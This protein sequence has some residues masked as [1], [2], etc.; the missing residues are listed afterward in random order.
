MATIEGPITAG[1][2]PFMGAAV[3]G[4]GLGYTSAEYFIELYPA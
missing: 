2:G 3:L 1:K 4:E